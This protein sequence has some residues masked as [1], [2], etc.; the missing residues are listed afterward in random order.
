M[1]FPV[2]EITL[3]LVTFVLNI[4]FGYWRSAT[5]KLTLEWFLSVHLPIPIVYGLRIHYGISIYY[6]PLFVIA[7]FLGQYTGG[8]LRRKLEVCFSLTKC[9]VIDI[10]RIVNSNSNSKF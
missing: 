4:F 1:G 3:L 7:Y 6:I 2:I 5:K 8:K 9:L 10:L